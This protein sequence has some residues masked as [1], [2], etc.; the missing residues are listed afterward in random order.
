LLRLRGIYATVSTLFIIWVIYKNFRTGL[1]LLGTPVLLAAIALGFTTS[2]RIAGPLAGILIAIYILGKAGKR[3]VLPIL[4]YGFIAVAAMYLT[5]PYL[6]GDPIGRLLDSLKIMSAYPRTQSVWFNGIE[7]PANALPISYFA[8]LFAIQLTEPVWFLFFIG[9]TAAVVG[10][11]MK[12][13]YSW[14]LF[15]LAGWF[16][17]PFIIFSTGK[18][19]FYDNFRQVLFILPPVFLLAGIAFSKIKQPKV[20]AALIMLVILPGVID[21]IR[22]HPYEYVYY[23]RFIGGVAGAQG[24]FELDYWATSYR[25]AAEYID[26]VAPPRSFVWVEGPA[27]AFQIFARKDLK[28]LDAYRPQLEHR[29]YYFVALSRYNLDLLAADADVIHTISR[30]GVPLTVIKKKQ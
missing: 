9:L 17:L 13:E 1:K 12:R 7:Y 2:T 11:I 23:N 8:T 15:L 25:E 4:I 19:S 24:R 30:D 20:Q 27:Q 18:F 21:G 16:I 26:H 5:W 28:V 14:L 22:L 6:W 3:A 10:F 29:N